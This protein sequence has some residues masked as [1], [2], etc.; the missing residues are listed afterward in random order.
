MLND[1]I[2]FG[3]YPSIGLE[4]LPAARKSVTTSNCGDQFA[5]QLCYQEGND[6]NVTVR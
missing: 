6:E 1:K 4:S 2:K 3:Q 5:T